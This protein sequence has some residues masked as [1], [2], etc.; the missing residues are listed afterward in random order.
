M[1]DSPAP[2][3]PTGGK[4][5]LIVEDDPVVARIYENRLTKAGFVVTVSVEGQDGFFSIV[6][7]KPDGVLLDLM[8]PNM[9]GVQILKKTR[10]QKH[11]ERTP[12]I[13][14]SNAYMNGMLQDAVEAGA[15]MVVN[16]SETGAME[17]IVAAFMQMLCSR[18]GTFAPRPAAPETS[19]ASD[20]TP[21]VN[22]PETSQDQ[23]ALAPRTV[24]PQAAPE[25]SVANDRNAPRPAPAARFGVVPT[26]RF[27]SNTPAP[28]NPNN[29]S[30][31]NSRGANQTSFF[32]RPSPSSSAA[33]PAESTRSSLPEAPQLPASG[34]STPRTP[35]RN[36]LDIFA[37]NG[38][39][40]VARIR[41]NMRAYSKEPASER[42][43]SHLQSFYRLV[44]SLTSVA[45]MA[46]LESIANF[47]ACLEAYLHELVSKPD[48]FQASTLRTLAS[49]VDVLDRMF[50]EAGKYECPMMTEAFV[51]VVDDDV[52]S[53]RAV[54]LS[55]QKARLSVMCASN[56]DEAFDKL[57]EIS[58]ELIVLDVNMPGLDGFELCSTI[59]KIP[60]Y[61]HTPILFVS[62]LNDFLSRAKSVTSGGNDFI[63]KPLSRIEMTIKSLSFVMKGRL[64]ALQEAGRAALV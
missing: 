62:G 58:F 40:T 27:R 64:P 45:G 11:F 49:A 4:R 7:T 30:D 25:S 59:R 1:S 22:V 17:N 2:S 15:S 35:E 6:T 54:T 34:S 63:S 14:F 24:T 50:K 31:S 55:L 8:L 51:L 3:N 29:P 32:K 42:G 57:K 28:E 16:K 26:S 61:E 46:S 48:S 44:H 23:P 60:T 12:I 43:K 5:I 20:A 47:S 10:A 41:T 56:C 9:D 21:P 19:A 36:L 52:I 53:Q 13:A 38:S 39:E 18:P 37:D 33:R